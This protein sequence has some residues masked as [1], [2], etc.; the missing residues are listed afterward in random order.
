M[1]K[2][3]YV[4]NFYP[5]ILGGLIEIIQSVFTATRSGDWYDFIAD[6]SGILAANIFFLLIKDVKFFI[7]VV[8]FPFK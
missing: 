7:A 4:M 3:D 6:L 1:N 5:L 2:K 8:K